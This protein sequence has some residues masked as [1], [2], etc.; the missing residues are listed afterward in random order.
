M[1][2]DE[3]IAMGLSNEQA[4][5]VLKSHKKELEGDYIPKNRFDEVNEK[6]KTANQ[7][8]TSRDEQIENLKK[9]EGTNTELQQTITTLQQQN[10]EDREKHQ[11]ELDAIMKTQLVRDNI[12]S[13][14]RVPY[15]VDDVLG[16]LDMSKI[17][18]DNG[19]LLG[20]SEQY[21]GMLKDKPHWFKPESTKGEGSSFGFNFKGREPGGNDGG[22]PNSGSTLNKQEMFG[23]ALAESS[24][25]GDT[26]KNAMEYFF[27]KN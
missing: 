19:R 26:T 21:E 10:K 23:K 27:G 6:L 22:D 5:S 17:Q 9:F 12:G 18:V 4:D 2:K 1:T 24:G 16:K 15:S 8:I 25:S 14:K 7:T 20:F 13:Q 11:E 3:L